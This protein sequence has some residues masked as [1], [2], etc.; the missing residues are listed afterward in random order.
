VNHDERIEAMTRGIFKRR[1][2]DYDYDEHLRWHEAGMAVNPAVYKASTTIA[3]V[4][5]DARAAWAA[6]DVEGMVQKAV[7]AGINHGAREKYI[8]IAAIDAIV[9]RVM[10]GAG[11]S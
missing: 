3:L 1:Y 2:P 8:D 10:Q 7:I 5:A 6:A 9:A 11:C 4:R